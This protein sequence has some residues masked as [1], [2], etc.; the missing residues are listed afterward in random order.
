MLRIASRMKAGFSAGAAAAAGGFAPPR[1][2]E[3]PAPPED[4]AAA[5][6]DGLEAGLRSAGEGSGLGGGGV[7]AASG[8]RF[9]PHLHI[10]AEQGL[11]EGIE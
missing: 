10:L 11:D 7:I 8:G 3:L 2:P 9:G 1:G 6:P 4:T 5:S